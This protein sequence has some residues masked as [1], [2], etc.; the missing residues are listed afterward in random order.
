MSCRKRSRELDEATS[1]KARTIMSKLPLRSD[2]SHY[3]RQPSFQCIAVIGIFVWLVLLDC[4]AGV[5]CLVCGFFSS[6]F[7][8]SEQNLVVYNVIPLVLVY[9]PC[10]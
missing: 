8:I 7:L 2:R 9:L 1:L 5:F 10:T 4:L 6:L 3:I